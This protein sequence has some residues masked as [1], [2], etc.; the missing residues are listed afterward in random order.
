VTGDSFTTTNGHKF[1]CEITIGNAG[2]LL[3]VYA[4]Q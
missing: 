1:R 4:M 2:S 3:N